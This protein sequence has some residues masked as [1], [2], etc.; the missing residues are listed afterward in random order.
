MGQDEIEKPRTGYR[1]IATTLIEEIRDGAWRVGEKLPTE[2]ALVDRFGVS[3][4]TV[5]EALR[6]LQDF[7]Y[8]S[9]RRGTR[10]EVVR[11]APDTSFVNS[12]RSVGELLDYVKAAHS[13]LLSADRVL[14]LEDQARQLDCT[15]GSEWVRLQLLRRREPTGAPFCYSE[16]YIDPRF[17]DVVGSLGPA[18][19]IH[20]GIE[21][22][23]G[24]VIARVIQQIEAASAS[25][26]VALKLQVP[27][28]A[29]ILLARTTFL[30][31]AGEVVELGLAHFASGRYRMKMALDRRRVTGA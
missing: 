31:A 21:E 14:L 17:A 19:D 28:G 10:S 4:N 24:V 30:S 27:A 13:T 9:K 12:I 25:A 5:R 11:S 16:A 20:R 7:G 8:L 15:A 6:E 26:G 29:P 23:Y 3:R 22:H 2:S 1:Q 18:Y